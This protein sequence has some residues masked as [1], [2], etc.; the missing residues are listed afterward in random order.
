MR[1]V[2][3]LVSLFLPLSGVSFSIEEAKA[4]SLSPDQK[5]ATTYRGMEAL[6]AGQHSVAIAE[7]S[8]LV[9][10]APT[11]GEYRSLRGAAYFDSGNNQKAIADFEEAIKC[12]DSRPLTKN[13]LNS[14]VANSIANDG[15][16][17]VVT[18]GK[19]VGD[20]NKAAQGALE[21]KDFRTAMGY[22]NVLAG[23]SKSIVHQTGLFG[24]AA[25]FLMM[26]RKANARIDLDELKREGTELDL[27]DL[28]KAASLS[29]AVKPHADT[30]SQ[31]SKSGP[32][33]AHSTKVTAA[34]KNTGK[35]SEKETQEWL[36][37]R[38]GAN[39]RN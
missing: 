8:K 34:P 26:G 38:Y 39:K 33:E 19:S 24:R 1:H 9:N 31:V 28:L 25:V 10:A 37:R 15:A 4:Q 14:A 30:A 12:G 27:S 16:G 36:N 6:K 29:E 21:K 3:L 5:A 13:S 20:I 22:Y 2:R 18:E 11:N 32:A 7:F 17:G 35:M 23:Q